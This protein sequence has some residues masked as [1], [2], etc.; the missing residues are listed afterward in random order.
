MKV[1]L[2]NNFHYR[3]GGSETV[4]FNIARIL[5]QAGFEVAYFSVARDENVPSPFAKYFIKDTSKMSKIRGL[6]KYFYNGDAA[7]KL[8]ELIINEKPDVAH[9]HLMWGCTAPAIFKVLKKYHVPLVHTVHDYRMVCPA[10]T[11]MTQGHICEACHGR[12][13]Y[14]CAIKR[15]SKGNLLMS[16]VMA[17]EMYY[18]NTFFNPSKNIRGLIYVSEFAKKIHEKYAP[19]LKNV[20]SMVLYNCASSVSAPSIFRGD[21]FLYYGRLSYEK[22][23]DLLIPFFRNHADLNLK[24]VGTGPSEEKLK[25][26]A[27]DCDNI[28]FLGFKSGE[29]LMRIVSN[30]S[31]VIVPSQWYENN[32]MTIIESY[33][34]GTPVIGSNL[35]GIPEIIE[36]GKTGYIFEH[37]NSKQLESVLILAS[38]LTDSKYQVMAENAYHFYKNNFSDREYVEKLME[39]YNQVLDA[40]K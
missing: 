27:G 33:S 15:C 36:D 16:T 35:G 21:Y 28:V 17:M 29:D 31:F 39:F 13:F 40:Y 7:G 38:N 5:K 24:V 2:I 10:Y 4:Y 32:P 14:K 6:L 8:E 37:R 34:L 3:K 9:A 30:A 26:E 25:A 1:L 19:S 23:V 22:G 12:S 18:R 11:F 20:P